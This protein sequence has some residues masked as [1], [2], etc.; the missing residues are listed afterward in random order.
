MM[1]H[2]DRF[3]WLSLKCLVLV[4]YM[5]VWMFVVGWL[6]VEVF[7]VWACLSGLSGS[8]GLMV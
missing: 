7:V 3:R 2:F 4:G 6:G 5:I 8:S 1:S